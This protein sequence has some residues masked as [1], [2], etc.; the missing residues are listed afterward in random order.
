MPALTFAVLLLY[1][2]NADALLGGPRIPPPK[3]S[4]PVWLNSKPLTLDELRGKVV[5]IDFW[6]YTCINCIR[7]FPR[8][9][10]WNKLYGPLGLVIIGVHTPEFKFDE[11]PALVEAAVK[12]FGLEFPIAVDSDGKIWD[13]FHNGAW[14]ADYL[15]DKDGRIADHHFGEGD[16]VLL[17]SEIQF[18]LKEANPKLDFSAAKYQVPDDSPQFGGACLRSTPETYLGTRMGQLIANEGGYLTDGKAYQAPK[19]VPIDH[20]ALDGAW[21]AAPEFVK[22]NPQSKDGASALTLHYR[23]K[24]VYL[25][26]GSENASPQM[27]YVSQDGKPLARDVRGVDVKQDGSGR[28]FLTLGTKRMYYVLQNPDFGDH[29]LKFTTASPDLDLYSFTFGNNCESRFDHR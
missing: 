11:D 6:E 8:L 12:R 24:S 25:V 22:R 5:L 13:A 3:F 21:T 29:T 19:S 17:E 15:I 4:T 10:K 7:T 23:A 26:G 16:Y 28:T 27:L 9:R 14:P 1:G 2:G 18:L 20:F